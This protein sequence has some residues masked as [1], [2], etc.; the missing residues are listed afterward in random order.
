MGLER[1]VDSILFNDPNVFRE[2]YGWNNGLYIYGS[3]IILR[4]IRAMKIM[5][6][7]NESGEFGKTSFDEETRKI[8]FEPVEE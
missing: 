3:S 2:D 7:L 4:K 1:H 5:K 8:E 6:A